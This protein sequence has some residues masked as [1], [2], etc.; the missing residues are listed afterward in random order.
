M[1]DAHE[2]R[3]M[4]IE[5]Q[6][7]KEMNALG[8]TV[9]VLYSE[10]LNLHQRKICF[11]SSWIRD[12]IYTFEDIRTPKFIKKPGQLIFSLIIWKIHF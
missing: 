12:D 6:R 7:T 10:S 8:K 2:M 1:E 3:V 4:I 11:L 9:H 5:V